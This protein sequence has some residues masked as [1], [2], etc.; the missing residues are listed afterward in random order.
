MKTLA[1]K[2]ESLPILTALKWSIASLAGKEYDFYKKDP[3]GYERVVKILEAREEIG[4]AV[5]KVIEEH[6][7]GNQQPQSALDTACGTGIIT[8]FIES[9]VNQ[10]GRVIGMDVS[11]P[12]IEYAATTKSPR[13]EWQEGSYED[14]KGIEDD[15]IDI[16]S[17]VAAHRFIENLRA[18]YGEMARV[19]SEDGLAIIP[20]IYPDIKRSTVK[21]IK[22]IVPEVGLELEIRPMQIQGLTN[23]L[24]VRQFMLFQKK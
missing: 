3:N 13:I 4:K 18:F 17:M 20:C 23:Q 24:Y 1:K 21:K 12:A 16:Y 7:Q 8:N 6:F 11:K 10:E 19:L 15:S 9:W 5:L 14:L 22:K 2:R